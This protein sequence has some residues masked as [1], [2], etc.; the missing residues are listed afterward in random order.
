MLPPKDALT[1]CF[2]HGAYRMAD[3]FAARDTGIRHLQVGSAEELA[4]H[5][6]EADVLVVSMMWRSELADTAKRLKFI[7][8]I[9]AGVDQ[10][11]K[12]L[13]RARGIRL[14][15]A[16]GVNA[17]AVA[18]HAMAMILALRRKLHTSRDNQAARFWRPMVTDI[19]SREDEL[20]G[21]TLLIIGLGRIGTRL[22]RLAK[23]FDMR[24]IATRR[25]PSRGGEGADEIYGNERLPE[26]LGA[27]DVVAITCP[28]TPA[29]EN[30]IDAKALGLMRPTAHL[31]N[32]GRGR[33][34]DE[35]ALVRALTSQRI[36]AAGLDVMREEPLPASS[37]LWALPN[38]LLTP[39]VAGE[40]QRYEDSVIDI[41]LDNLA[42]LWRGETALRN[43]I[44]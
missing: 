4:R 1:I 12:E 39:H 42:R 41:L 36:A 16:A 31:I 37:P 3:R 30:L 10:Y 14:A 18:E 35:D 34:V 29:T 44:V 19:A 22:G 27:A 21:K 20:G 24:V 32:V 26:L 7:Q 2:A 13:L 8:S 17:H 9:S 28:L 33:I 40:T 25:D 11:D 15:S 38:A 43:Q 6:P 5:L 23:A